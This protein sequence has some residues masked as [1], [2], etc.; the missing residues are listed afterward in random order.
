MNIR[1]EI[2]IKTAIKSQ[3][4]TVIVFDRKGEQ[5]PEYQGRY[6]AVRESILRDAPS[7]TVFAHGFTAAAEPRK[8]SREDW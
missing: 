5:V 8:V 1:R 6:E 3:D 4:D 7:D 2:M